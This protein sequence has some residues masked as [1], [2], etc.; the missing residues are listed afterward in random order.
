MKG[1]ITDRE[2]DPLGNMMLDYLDGKTNAFVS[3]ESTTLDMWKMR[4]DTMFRTFGEMNRIERKALGLCRGEIL[5]AGAG[6][7]CHSR[8]MVKNQKQVHCIDISPGCIDVMIRQGL[9]HVRHASLFSLGEA[10]KF[11]TVLMLM[12]GIGICGSVDGLNLFFQFLPDILIP[13]GQVLMD[14]TDIR[15]LYDS[16]GIPVNGDAYFGETSFVMTY[17]DSRSDPF[18]WLYVDFETLEY[19]AGFHGVACEKVL[20]DKTGRYLA[21]LNLV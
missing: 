9:P 5:D 18:D 8:Y 3:V 10:K 6:S 11:D 1:I 20:S 15:V 19:Y 14:S 2:K 16:S 4:G 7:G 13:G 21:R 17:R 12:N